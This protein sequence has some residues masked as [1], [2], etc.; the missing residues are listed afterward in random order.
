YIKTLVSKGPLNAPWGL[1]QAPDDFGRF[2]NDLL[3]GNFGDG[4]V[5]AFD[6]DTGDFLGQV[7][8]VSGQPL[9]IDG[10]W[11]IKFGNGGAGG[12]TDDIYF[13]SGPGDEQHGL[14]GEL[15]AVGDPTHVS[16]GA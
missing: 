1:A 4:T 14:F 13:T 7:T 2:S 11:A 5:N 9:T 16:I 12:D 10:L 15:G 6:P 8:D 3:V